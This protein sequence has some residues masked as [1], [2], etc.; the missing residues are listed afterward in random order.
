MSD[1]LEKLKLI[2]AGEYIEVLWGDACIY[3]RVTEN[4]LRSM[5]PEHLDTPMRNV[6]RYLG[7][8]SGKLMRY[9][10]LWIGQDEKGHKLAIIPLSLIKD[11]KRSAGQPAE[12]RP[13]I[14]HRFYR[15]HGK[16]VKIYGVKRVAD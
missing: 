2:K 6:G 14:S 11:V 10:V 1:V 5:K 15:L 3:E 4:M 16:A 13:L 8:R 9:L 12:K 7:V